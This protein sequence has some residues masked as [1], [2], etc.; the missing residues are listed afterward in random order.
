M[1]TKTALEKYGVKNNTAKLIALCIKAATGIVGASLVLE[2]SHPYIALAV[3]ATGA[4]ANEV[5][6]FYHWNK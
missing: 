3:L 4:I 6:N 2:Q 1:D 5:I